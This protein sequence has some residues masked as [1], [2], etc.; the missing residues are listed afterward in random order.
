MQ[1]GDHGVE[2]QKLTRGFRF[3]II[4]NMLLSFGKIDQAN[5]PFLQHF[6]LVNWRCMYTL[7]AKNAY[8]IK[9]KI[10]E[11]SSIWGF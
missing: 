9:L 11:N 6:E 5:Q 7:L 2:E 3:L 10:L 4:I 1:P 8:E